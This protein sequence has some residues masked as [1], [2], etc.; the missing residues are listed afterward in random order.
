MKN[1]IYVFLKKKTV[2]LTFVNVFIYETFETH[3]RV[4][5]YGYQMFPSE[6]ACMCCLPTHFH[7]N[8]KRMI[9]I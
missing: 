1:V 6:R 5:L 8:K 2:L 9:L 3:L 4:R 7:K